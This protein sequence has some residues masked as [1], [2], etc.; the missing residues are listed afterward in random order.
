MNPLFTDEL[1][2]PGCLRDD[3]V[4]D[5]GDSAAILGTLWAFG[6]A[7]MVPLPVDALTDIPVRHPDNTQWWGKPDRF[8]RDQLVAVLCGL[9]V[10]NEN[11][12]RH[13]TTAGELARREL[14]VVY[15]QSAHAKRGYLTAWNTR[16][17]GSIEAATK[18][19]D[20]TGPEVWAL[21]IRLLYGANKG[22]KARLFRALLPI[23]DIELLV[24]A[25]HWRFFRKD[26]V[27]RNHMLSSII[28]QRYHP[29]W[30]AKLAGWVNDWEDL[31]SRW[32]AHCAAVGEYP[33]GHLF[34]KAVLSP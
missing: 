30:T 1:G 4:L 6:E 32:E 22:L 8:S 14:A 27:T 33:T 5:M 23:L 12:N 16:R 13:G 7:D 2:Y 10:R 34:R 19:P 20:I 3:G 26:R 17:N 24:S 21:W 9:I 11:Y 29:T 28:A 25:I 18:F 31:I 15:L